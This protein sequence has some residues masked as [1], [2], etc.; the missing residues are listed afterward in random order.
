MRLVLDYW[1]ENYMALY[2]AGVAEY[3]LGDYAQAKQHLQEF[4]AIYQNEDG[5]RQN[6][7]S[8]LK[9]IETGVKPNLLKLEG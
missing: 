8:A 7:K 3:L 1:P 9:G 6:A 4:L 2:H 5:W